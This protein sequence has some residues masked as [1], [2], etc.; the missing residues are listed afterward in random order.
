MLTY[1]KTTGKFKG[2]HYIF[3][4]LTEGVQW[5]NGDKLGYLNINNQQFEDE[6]AIPYW[7]NA[8]VGDWVKSDDGCVVQ[9]LNR[10]DRMKRNK[11]GDL[12]RFSTNGIP[13]FTIMFKFVF[14]CFAVWN[15]ADGTLNAGL[16]LAKPSYEQRHIRN[17]SI[18]KNIPSVLG[19]YSNKRKRYFC[20]LAVELADPY[21]AFVKTLRHYNLM[22][23]RK[24]RVL[25]AKG[26]QMR[27]F[28][29][30]MNDPFVRKEINNQAQIAIKNKQYT[31]MDDFKE[32]L[33]KALGDVKLTTEDSVRAIKEVI[34]NPR[35]GALGKLKAAEMNLNM[36]RFIADATGTVQLEGGNNKSK[37]I[38]N[39]KYEALPEAKDN[40]PEPPSD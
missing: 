33:T 21:L 20:Y 7:R 12:M 31:S 18:G 26:S 14:G 15:R 35:S 39:A 13:V 2:D 10:W 27:Q 25:Q 11:G 38:E 5:L 32:R 17:V 40:L 3:E 8:Q 22:D 24:N 36:Q 19:K 6:L 4:S 1:T 9:I 34:D 29:L 16:C 28:V 30:A 37:A 23:E